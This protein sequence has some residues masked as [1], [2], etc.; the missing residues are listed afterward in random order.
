MN[1]LSKIIAESS[2]E[3][4]KGLFSVA[5]IN[6][7]VFP[8]NCFMVSMDKLETTAIFKSETTVG[9][10][11]ER[12][13]NYTLIG[14]DVSIPFYAVGFIAEIT[15]C[16][17]REDIPVLVVSTYSRDYILVNASDCEKSRDVLL[18][19]GMSEKVEVQK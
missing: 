11:I 7:N 8:E 5:K 19:M 15:K 1:D 4:E 14:I 16:L 2:F 3:I 6:S 18:N 12:K 10:V 13:D 17:S 9:P